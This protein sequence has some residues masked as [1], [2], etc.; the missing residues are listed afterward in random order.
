[1]LWPWHGGAFLKQDAKAQALKEKDS[2]IQLYKNVKLLY[3]KRCHKKK[4][5]RQATEGEK[6]FALRIINNRLHIINKRSVFQ[7]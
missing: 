4:K 2:N 6:I 3:N 5:W 7:V 1:M